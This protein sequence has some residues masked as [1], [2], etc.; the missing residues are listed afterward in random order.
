[1]LVL[2]VLDGANL[3]AFSTV[4]LQKIQL[5]AFDVHFISD[6]EFSNRDF[7]VV[8]TRDNER[9]HY[10]YGMGAYSGG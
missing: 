5:N 3:G 2:D 10:G 6:W 4:A 9:E 7:F 1:M 8:E